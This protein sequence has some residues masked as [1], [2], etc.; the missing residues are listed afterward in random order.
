MTSGAADVRP[1][2]HEKNIEHYRT[3]ALG[4]VW[5][6]VCRRVSLSVCVCVC[7]C[8]TVLYGVNRL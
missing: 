7:V 8:V 3:L 6:A 1:D 2:R 4:C 5:F